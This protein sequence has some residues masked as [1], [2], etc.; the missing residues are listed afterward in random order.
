MRKKG[1][2]DLSARFV[3]TI[4]I[5]LVFLILF[6]FFVK[7]LFDK[8]AFR[9]E[10]KISETGPVPTA[11][12]SSPD[13]SDIYLVSQRVVFDGRESY[14]PNYK[15]IGYFWDIDGDF[16]IDSRESNFSYFYYEPGEYNITLKVVNDD[17]KIGAASQ[18]VKVYTNNKKISNLEDSM[19]F[20]RDNKDNR[21]D[22]LRLIPVTTWNDMDGLH[23]IPFYVY[24][25][26]DPSS[27]LTEGQIK[28]AMDSYGKTHAYVFD[29]PNIP[30]CDFSWGGKIIRVDNIDDFYFGF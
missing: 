20:I 14:D 27:S 16:I 9:F 18:V 28:E 19:F 5:I 17:G 24:Y 8:A 4:I 12:I 11:V 2:I 15:I 7:N 29:D 1:A 30:C 26:K 22:I 21:D 10:Q 23:N 25:V 6:S 3:V 13:P